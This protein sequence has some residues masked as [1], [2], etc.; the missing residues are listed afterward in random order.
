[1]FNWIEPPLSLEK[2]QHYFLASQQSAGAV[3]I[4]APVALLREAQV[5]TL[6]TCQGAN[7]PGSLSLGETNPLQCCPM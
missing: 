4:S 2:L 7:A 3:A 5:G 6:L 1:M